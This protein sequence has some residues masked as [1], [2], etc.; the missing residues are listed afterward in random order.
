MV[1]DRPQNFEDRG[2][3]RK[4]LA[5]ILAVQDLTESAADVVPGEVRQRIEGLRGCDTAI[6]AC[7]TA[8]ALST[9]PPPTDSGAVFVP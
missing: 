3:V 8:K 6:L 2:K 7:F 5:P 1:L 4:P 9:K